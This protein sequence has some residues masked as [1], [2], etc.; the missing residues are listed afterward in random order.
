MCEW[1]DKEEQSKIENKIKEIV[2]RNPPLMFQYTTY[3]NSK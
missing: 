3:K 1:V 2:T